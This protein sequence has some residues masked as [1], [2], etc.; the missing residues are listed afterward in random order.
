MKVIVGK[1]KGEN[2]SGNSKAKVF[3]SI[4]AEVWPEYSETD[5]T[6][7]GKHCKSKWDELCGT[8]QKHATC[9][10]QTGKGVCQDDNDNQK[11]N[12]TS[13]DF[14]IPSEAEN[15]WKEI[16]KDLKFF[17]YLYCITP[18]GHQTILL[19]QPDNT[20]PDELIDPVLHNQPSP[21]P[22][23]QTSPSALLATPV[24]WTPSA[25]S[26]SSASEM[27]TPLPQSM[28]SA[29]QMA[30]LASISRLPKKQGL[31][32]LL[33]DIYQQH[34]S[35]SQQQ[36]TAEKV[37]ETDK[38][39]KSCNHYCSEKATVIKLLQA[40]VYTVEKAR[41]KI[42]C[43]DKKLKVCEKTPTPPSSPVRS[44]HAASPPWDIEEDN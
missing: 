8:Y 37:A 33:G 31:D 2:S 12:T 10:R 15:I 11:S 6:K 29:S 28:L 21:A 35:T 39:E 1:K 41:E 3:W 42:H 14:Y 9:L 32:E 18:H 4:G 30:A 36:A 25:G 5:P 19:Q 23:G 44:T 17:P 20:I 16:V 43:L 27:A 34:V 40:D 13:L 24:E 38:K 7:T 22:E 26:L